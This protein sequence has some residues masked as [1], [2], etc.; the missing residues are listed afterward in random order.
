M[1]IL[2]VDT[3]LYAPVTPFFLDPLRELGVSHGFVDEAQFLR[4]LETSL[5]HKVT[6]RI[7]G[8]RPPLAGQL[9]RRLLEAALRLQPD[10]VLIVKGAYI[11]PGVLLKIKKMTGAILVNYATDN[12]FNPAVT[13]LNLL[14]TIPLYDLYA[15]TKS[16]ILDD[17]RA[18]GCRNVTY[19][20]FGYN[21]SIHFPEFPSSPD[22]IRR[23]TADVA[24][25][26][27]ADPERLPFIERLLRM[28]GVAVALYG[29]NWGRFKH[30][31]HVTRGVVKGRDYRLALGG[32]KIALGLLRKANRD[33]HSLRSFEIP[34]CGTLM[35]AERT[36]EHLA[37]F[38]E[39]RDAEFFSSCE[40]MEEKIRYYLDHE[41]QR[42]RV[43]ESGRVRVTTGGHT[44]SDRLRSI[45]RI[46]GP[47][48]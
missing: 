25:I 20:P 26:G 13:T 41:S 32:A 18:T 8:R 28:R 31:R 24:F 9:N 40:E 10:V 2:L 21:P 43:A 17:I 14:R 4:G 23:F 6:Y 15:S 30:L 12:P 35:L 27:E 38:E 36:P 11:T 33:Q 5:I 47:S 45:L 29:A 46:V 42:R 1:R 39:G 19:V 44:Y 34:A 16:T 48:G 22:E 7:L 37:I 3:S